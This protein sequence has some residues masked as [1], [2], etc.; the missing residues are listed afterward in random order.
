MI[1]AR[2]CHVRGS[3]VFAPCGIDLVGRQQ[4]TEHVA[5]CSR[6]VVAHPS[7]ETEGACLIRNLQ[8]SFSQVCNQILALFE[9][10]C[11]VHAAHYR[12]NE[13]RLLESEDSEGDDV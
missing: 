5:V 10:F 6:P 3:S 11:E 4:L 7:E 2:P 12:A 9:R 8:P 13:N 1:D